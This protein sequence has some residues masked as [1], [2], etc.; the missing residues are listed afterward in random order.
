MGDKK[1]SELGNATTLL[2]GSEVLP[3]VQSGSTVKAKVSDILASN[4]VVIENTTAKTLT[5]E[6]SGK[7][8]Y[9]TNAGTTTITFTDTLPVGFT[10]TIIGNLGTVVLAQIGSPS[11]TLA[12]PN[13]FAKVTCPEPDLFVI[14]A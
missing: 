12:T 3:I 5:A 11:F 10:C 1:I 8:I 7:I 4:Q 6:D 9:C 13:S 14:C 2:T